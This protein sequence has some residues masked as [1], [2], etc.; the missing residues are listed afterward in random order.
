MTSTLRRKRGSLK[1][2]TFC[3][4]RGTD[5]SHSRGQKFYLSKTSVVSGEAK[6]RFTIN[7]QAAFTNMVP[8]K[9]KPSY[10]YVVS[11]LEY[12]CAISTSYLILKPPFSV[13]P[14]PQFR[15]QAVVCSSTRYFLVSNISSFWAIIQLWFD[16]IVRRV[17]Q[18]SVSQKFYP[19]YLSKNVPIFVITSA[20]RDLFKD[21]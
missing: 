8:G 19:V 10:V 5:I 17:W 2:V 12:T 1:R 16:I 20:T 15:F 21:L 14:P 9:Q 18:T 6:P 3:L 13:S 11:Q 7:N 4:S